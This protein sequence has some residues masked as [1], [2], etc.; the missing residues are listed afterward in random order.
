MPLHKLREAKVP[1]KVGCWLAAF[2]DSAHRQQAVAVE[3]SVSSL[4]S[5]I[6]GVPQGTVLGPVLFLLH[7]ADIAND[8]SASTTTTS[9]LDDT[10]ATRSFV[11]TES[12]C[13]ALQQDLASIYR[14]A[15]EVN[16]TF[17]S[18]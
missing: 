11:D 15:E 8:V 14:W 18:D 9:Y 2:L 1:G 13:H 4:T 12:D 10:R 17:N 6:S 5:V 3:G 7:I 16:M